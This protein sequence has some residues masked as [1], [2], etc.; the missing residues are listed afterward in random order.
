MN[1]AVIVIPVQGT[2]KGLGKQTQYRSKLEWCQ[3]ERS[4]LDSRKLWTTGPLSKFIYEMNHFSLHSSECLFILCFL[5]SS[6]IPDQ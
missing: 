3:L 5:W 1:K 4:D 6:V 2:N